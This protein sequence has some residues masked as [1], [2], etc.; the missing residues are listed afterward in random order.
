MMYQKSFVFTTDFILPSF[1]M[2]DIYLL[3]GQRGF[4]FLLYSYIPV[5]AHS[6]IVWTVT[7]R[8]DGGNIWSKAWGEEEKTAC[9]PI[10]QGLLQRTEKNFLWI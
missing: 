6:R 9:S 8:T 4:L 3:R 5:T 10:L 1:K 7:L 2:T